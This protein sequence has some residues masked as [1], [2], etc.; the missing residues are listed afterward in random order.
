MKL[1]EIKPL[2]EDVGGVDE[3]WVYRMSA[4]GVPEVYYGYNRHHQ[5][6]QDADE[7]LVRA[8][9]GAARRL[10]DDGESLRG[11][12]RMVELAGGPD[13]VVI[14]PIEGYED[15]PS[16]F[17]R[18]NDERRNDPDSITR[19]SRFPTRVMDLIRAQNPGIS[20][21][22]SKPEPVMTAKQALASS[23]FSPD[24]MNV[25][26]VAARKAAMSGGISSSPI[27]RDLHKTNISLDDFRKKYFSA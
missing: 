14:E 19:P 9:L 16:A 26:S 27:L 8:V 6:D 4:P 20:W 25:I 12:A 10:D 18:R 22:K 3:F 15:E 5:M 1:H 7:K 24:E 2:F 23:K 11:T 17:I 21:K 13:N